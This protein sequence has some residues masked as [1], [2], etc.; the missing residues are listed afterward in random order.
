MAELEPRKSRGGGRE[1]PWAPG[2]RGGEQSDVLPDRN[3]A[4]LSISSSPVSPAWYLCTYFTINEPFWSQAK[5]LRL[6]VQTFIQTSSFW[7]FVAV[8]LLKVQRRF[9]L[10]W[11]QPGDSRPR[12]QSHRVQKALVVAGAPRS[13]LSTR[14]S[15]SGGGRG[16]SPSCGSCAETGSWDRWVTKHSGRPAG[17]GVGL[18]PGRHRGGWGEAAGGPAGASRAWDQIL[19]I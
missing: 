4:L 8:C 13:R 2:T 19:S 16:G 15:P 5:I 6:Y 10:S 1:R 7:K 17:R 18:F 11:F 12:E 9:E 3:A 14:G